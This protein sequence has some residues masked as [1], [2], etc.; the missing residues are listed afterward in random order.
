MLDHTGLKEL[1]P[2]MDV[3]MKV[4]KDLPITLDPTTMLILHVLRLILTKYF[5]I[6]G[7]HR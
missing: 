6:M 2:Y 7:S 4:M 3:V 1:A 5:E